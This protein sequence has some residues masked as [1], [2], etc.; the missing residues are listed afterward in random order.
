M[1]KINFIIKKRR[2]GRFYFSIIAANSKNLNPDDPQ[3]TKQAV[4]KAIT[5][6]TFHLQSGLFEIIDE[7]KTKK[8]I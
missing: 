4:K 1:R 7:T 2:D 3:V 6:L 5:S 8:K